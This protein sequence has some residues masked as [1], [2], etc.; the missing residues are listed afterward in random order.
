MHVYGLRVCTGEEVDE[1][2]KEAERRRDPEGVKA[3]SHRRA[4]ARTARNARRVSDFR[5]APCHVTLGHATLCHIHAYILVRVRT[6][7]FG[8]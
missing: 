2:A 8:Q 4:N 5:A 6:C 7:A 1:G 3:R